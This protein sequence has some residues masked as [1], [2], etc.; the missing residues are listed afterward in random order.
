METHL[1]DLAYLCPPTQKGVLS[2]RYSMHSMQKG[3]GLMLQCG[4]LLYDMSQNHG[5]F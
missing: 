3:S 1:E 5:V 4:S 2:D